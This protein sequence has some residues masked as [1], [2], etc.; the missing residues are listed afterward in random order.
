V[1]IAPIIQRINQGDRT[2]FADIVRHFQ[3]PLFGYLGRL[4]LSQ[5]TAEDI[6]QET[7]LRAWGH[8]AD[9]D[10]QRAGFS[11]WLYTIAH[12]LALNELAKASSRREFSD[13]D[14][15]LELACEGGQ[16]PQIL[17]DAQRR[18]DVQKALR[19]LP[20]NDRSALALAYFQ[21]LDLAVIA[22]IENCTVP[23]IKVRLHRARQRLMQLL[24]QRYG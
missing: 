8:L 14:L 7:F 13:N 5:A 15:A 18:N 20:A 4:G 3:R 12:R 11:T 22:R 21:E 6:A 2:A 23:A 16:P 24:E 9:F 1:D 17:S 10:P 19:A